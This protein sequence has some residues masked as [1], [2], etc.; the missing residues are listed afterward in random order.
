MNCIRAPRSLAVRDQCVKVLRLRPPL[1]R[2]PYHSI[3]VSTLPLKAPAC[4]SSY[5]PAFPNTIYMLKVRVSSAHDGLSEEV[6]TVTH[7]MCV[8]VSICCVYCSIWI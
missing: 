5:D 1:L 4:R 3:I 8:N 6:E 2:P 7:V